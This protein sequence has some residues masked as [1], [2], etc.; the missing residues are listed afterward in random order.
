MAD[1]TLR[2]S[3]QGAVMRIATVI[4]V[5]MAA[6][7]AATP[8]PVRAQSASELPCVGY[9]TFEKKGANTEL[10]GLAVGDLPA[11]VKVTLNCSGISCPFSTKTFNMKNSVKMLAL[12]DMFTDPVFSPGTVLEMRV[13]KPGW[14][15]KVFQYEIRSSDDPKATTECLTADG[16]KTVACLKTV[17]A[18]R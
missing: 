10:I 5:A 13:T 6:G 7:L 2:L 17:P 15:G 3:K 4:S 1:S 8:N 18:Q 14:I 16:S 9:A 11:G 12:T